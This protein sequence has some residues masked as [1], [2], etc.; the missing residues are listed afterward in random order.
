MPGKLFI[1]IVS[2]DGSVF[3]GEARALKAPGVEGSFEVLYNHAP[4]IAAIEIGPLVV[5]DP[6]GEEIVFATSGGFV[7]VLNNTVTVLAETAEPASAIDVE[8]ARE[9]EQRALE[10]LQAGGS[11]ID[12]ARAQRALERARNR[13][14]VAM[15]RVGTRAS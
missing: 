12:R 5:V 14:R 9:A 3:R 13:L 10:R 2:P 11:D 8:R 4:M 15:G 1:D 6:S 7:E